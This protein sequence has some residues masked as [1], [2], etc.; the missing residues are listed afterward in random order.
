MTQPIRITTRQTEE[1]YKAWTK[2]NPI[3]R[4]AIIIESILVILWAI[5]V[6]IQ[7]NWI[8]E[9]FLGIIIVF[10]HTMIVDPFPYRFTMTTTLTISD[11]TTQ[12]SIDQNGKTHSYSA[13]WQKVRMQETT[14]YY[15]Y[16][17]NFRRMQIFR[18]EDLTD[19]T[20]EELSAFLSEKLG[21][22]YIKL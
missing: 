12:I 1:L 16:R 13:N 19:C 5:L 14:D 20:A 15:I 18:K 3:S 21:K 11:S 9:L 22:R 10:C 7:F 4:V 2:A 8:V 17:T 6:I